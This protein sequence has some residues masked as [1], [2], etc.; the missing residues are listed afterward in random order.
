MKKY[1]QNLNNLDNEIELPSSD[2]DGQL[3]NKKN[4][5]EIPIFMY[6]NSFSFLIDRRAEE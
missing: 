4:F 2:E 1:R 5:W 6:I 3:I